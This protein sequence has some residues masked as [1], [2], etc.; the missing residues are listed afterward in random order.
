[1]FNVSKNTHYTVFWLLIILV[2]FVF[3][4]KKVYSEVFHEFLIIL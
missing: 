3:V 1:M 4:L 2:V